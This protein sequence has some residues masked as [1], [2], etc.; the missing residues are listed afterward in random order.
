MIGGRI[1]RILLLKLPISRLDVGISIS[2]PKRH[3]GSPYLTAVLEDVDLVDVNCLSFW[4][5]YELQLV[6]SSEV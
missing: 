5:D 2:L 4:E 6:S 1:I 3:L